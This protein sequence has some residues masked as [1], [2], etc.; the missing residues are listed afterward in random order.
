MNLSH[1]LICLLRGHSTERIPS[2]FYRSWDGF[3][4]I[5]SLH[6][7]RCGKMLGEYRRG[8]VETRM[9]GRTTTK[10]H[11]TEVADYPKG[12]SILDEEPYDA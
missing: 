10:V 2:V 5:G 9:S 1:K 7:K 6:C 12:R 11:F 3:Q 8:L 4:E